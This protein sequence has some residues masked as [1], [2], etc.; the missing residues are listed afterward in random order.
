MAGEIRKLAERASAAAS[1]IADLIGSIRAGVSEAVVAM[2]DEAGQVDS[3]VREAGRSAE[4]L[5]RIVASLEAT[6]EQAQAI[7]GRAKHIDAAVA[8]GRVAVEELASGAEE[9]AATAEEMAAQS[10][11][12]G[13]AVR[14]LVSEDVGTNGHR[15]ASVVA[16]ERTALDLKTLVD[17]FRV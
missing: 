13:D 2:R 17:R 6:N 7:S 14:R 8:R 10:A 12:V 3:A 15:T 4:A 9:E 11:Q 5:D 1:Q 16:L